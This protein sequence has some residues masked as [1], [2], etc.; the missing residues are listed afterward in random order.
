MPQGNAAAEL[1]LRALSESAKDD[2]GCYARALTSAAAAVNPAYGLAWYGE[3]YRQVACDADWFAG[4]LVDNASVEGDGARKLWALAAQCA[5][6]VGTPISEKIRRHA[7][8][9]S[10]HAQYYIRI[11][12]IIFPHSISA[13]LR[14]ELDQ[15][16]P[17]YLP[18][19]APPASLPPKTAERVIDELVQM[20]IGEIR[21]RINQ[22]L[23]R[24]VAHAYCG[25]HGDH[26]ALQRILDRLMRDETRHIH[27][28]AKILEDYSR[29]GYRSLVRNVM[30][31][32]MHDFNMITLDEV[33]ADLFD[34][35]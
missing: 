35:S 2:L 25:D 27:Y 20:N 5:G 11:V 33:A 23:L 18:T 14:L 12:D 15:I 4:S 22:L 8:D 1:T 3:H 19:S 26:D 13:G 29:H 31:T 17:H 6:S 28:T 9:E 7:I 16:S 24:P 32:R 21:T 10:R 30:A 34:G